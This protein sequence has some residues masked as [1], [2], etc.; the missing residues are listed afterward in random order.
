MQLNGHELADRHNRPSVTQK[1][2]LRTFF[3]NGGEYV[4]PYDVSAVT[5]FSKLS[6]TTPSSLID[7]ATGLLKSGITSGTIKMSYGISGD[8][9]QS[10]P[11]DG[12]L[13]TDGSYRVTSNYL[14]DAV[15]FPAYVPTTQA[16]GILRL[17]VGDYLCVLDGTLDLSGAYYLNSS[18]IEIQ[19]STSSVQDYID[20]WTVKFAQ[21]SLYQDMINGFKLYN[22]V[23][24]MITEVVLFT[25]TNRLVNKHVNLDSQVD[26]K[27]TTELTVQNRGLENATKAIL[28]ESAIRNP[29]FRIQK[30]NEGSVNLPSRVTIVDYSDSSGLVTVTSDNTML[31]NFDTQAIVTTTN[32]AL[33][34]GVAGNYALTC[35]YSILN[36]NYVEGPFY[37][38]VK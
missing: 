9:D 17:G 23:F 29:Q 26:L 22:D 15:W 8:P 12:G 13:N 10:L 27:V 16:S 31:Y 20:V 6:N 19:N 30:V 2:A 1:V 38:V 33:L 7:P 11:H 5:V 14:A 3:L 32:I 34:G 35:A 24:Q 18:S 28:E 36:Q 21:S 37:F 25:T 4:D